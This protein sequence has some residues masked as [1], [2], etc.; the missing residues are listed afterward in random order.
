M[1]RHEASSAG[2]VEGNGNGRANFRRASVIRDASREGDGS[3]APAGQRRAVSL[4][5]VS[6]AL[7]LALF[8]TAASA[9]T[10]HHPEPFSPLDGSGS[11]LALL[12]ASGIAFDQTTGN[13]FVTDG[14]PEHERIAILGREGGTPVGLATPYAIPGLPYGLNAGVPGLAF[15]NSATSPARGTLYVNNTGTASIKKYRRNATTERYESTGEVTIPAAQSNI[16]LSVDGNGDLY[17]G[18]EAGG[19]RTV[20][21][22]DPVGSLLNEYELFAGQGNLSMRGLAADDAGDLFV[23]TNNGLFE[24]P[25]DGSGEIDPTTFTKLAEGFISAVT[26]D[27]ALDHVF[28]AGGEQIREFDASSGEKIDEFGAGEIG[29]SGGIAVDP[30]N[31]RIYV[32]D[33]W[34][35]TGGHEDVDVFGPGVTI[36][37]VAIGPA[38]GITGT[39]ATLNGSV[40]PEDIEVTK[41]FFEWGKDLNGIPNYEHESACEGGIGKDSATYQVTAAVAG[42]TAN[43]ATYHFRLVAENENG[44]EVTADRSF[45]TATTVSTESASAVGP[46]AA[47]LNGLVRA[48]GVQYTN[49]VFEYG[50]TSSFGFEDEAPCNPPAA[51]IPPDFIAHP[52]SLALSG[53]NTNATYKF[54]LT[55]TNSNGTLSGETFTFTTPGS[56]RISEVQ[57]N[58]A[59]QTSLSLGASI[60]PSGFGTSY[61]FEWGPTP[62]YGNVAPLEFEPF[63]GSG[64]EPVLVKARISGLSAGNAYHYR[65][66]ATSARGVT[67]SRDHVAETLNS[68]GLSEG[69]CF[70]L[71]SRSDAG[72]VAIPGEGNSHIEMHY[73]AATA[74]AGGLAYEVESGYPEA[75]KG[76]EVLYHAQRSPEGWESTQLSTPILAQNERNEGNSVSNA[77][78]WLSNDLSCGFTESTQPLTPDPSMRLV[79]EEGGSNLYRI[80]PDGSYTPITTLPPENAKHT[81]GLFNYAVAYASQD[82]EVT[83]FRSHYAYS[84]IPAK[85][86][87]GEDRL[88]EWREGTLRNA[89]IVPGPGGEEVSVPAIA[90]WG[91][92]GDVGA[93]DTQNAVSE[94]GS[95]IFLTADRQTSPNPGEI[96]KEAV[97]VREDGTATRDVSLS[98]T[99]TPDEGAQYQWATADGSRVFF[100]ANAGLTAESNSE[101]TDLYE[102]DLETEELTDRSVTPAE[103]GAEVAGLLGASADG[104]QAYF[105][106]R[107]QLAPGKGPSRAQNVSAGTYSI[108]GERAGEITFV[109]TYTQG[110]RDHVLIE[111]QPNW[112]AQVSPDGRYLLFESSAKVTGYENDGL[113]EAYLYDANSQETICVSCRQDGQPSP[114]ERYGRPSYSLLTRSEAVSNNLHSPRFL[115][116]RNGEAQVFFSSPDP[117]ASGAV[118]GQ[119]NIYEWSHNQIF[120][121]TGALADSMKTPFPGIFAT[122]AGASSDGSDIYLMTPE[123][124]TWEDGDERLSAYDARIGGGFPE[125]PPAPGPCNATAEG[126][127]QGPG[128]AVPVAPGAASATFNGPGNPQQKQ[129]PP[130]KKKKAKKKQPQKHSKKKSNKKKSSS[131]QARQANGNRRN[132]K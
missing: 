121:L 132:G 81:L 36:P 31:A 45:E 95:R 122:F 46:T 126:S 117:L 74:G 103:G 112:T 110:D 99:A 75:T 85:P 116:E 76:A 20:Y 71:V 37:T 10:T 12:E 4:A 56:P 62:A 23:A 92:A 105:S 41:C 94:D 130:K 65:V 70:E 78:E 114:N 11:N 18:S 28:A 30:E 40:I 55:A 93:Q 111:S 63:I 119:T 128:Q 32:A 107:N 54:R 96:G 86:G 27:P 42:L 35:L 26:F 113:L 120:R 59:S 88:Y 131:K 51:S 100:T 14:G 57:A 8:A 82:C 33:G 47:T 97:F 80:N 61:R 90:G 123:T 58:S 21:E 38:S 72:P 60:D 19:R 52:V 6:V 129:S 7:L 17:A 39:R 108:Y 25:A 68:C 101:G 15:D 91:R 102:Y 67:R 106:S 50:L 49:C 98:Q 69:R 118:E 124:L 104:S 127:C 83:V 48:E 2:T 66:T 89:G 115:T 43:G 29:S 125:P 24:F 79:R 87:L 9:A 109:G 64:T 16:A 73:Q 53:L 34:K 13:V 22:F 84:G 1:R 44:V 3:G 77:T 5:L